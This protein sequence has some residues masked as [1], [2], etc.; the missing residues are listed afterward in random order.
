MG[1]K[2]LKSVMPLLSV[3]ELRLL[4]NANTKLNSFSFEV[5]IKL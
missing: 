5:A 1:I 4:C 2:L 3:D